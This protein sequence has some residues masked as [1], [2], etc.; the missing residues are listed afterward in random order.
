V[1]CQAKKPKGG[2]VTLDPVAGPRTANM[3]DRV[4]QARIYV[5]MD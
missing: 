5:S 4:K 1:F 3:H 2:W